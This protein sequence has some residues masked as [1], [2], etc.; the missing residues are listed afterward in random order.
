MK[1]RRITYI[2]LAALSL[3]AASC[4]YPFTPDPEDGSG[5][6]VMEG[7]IF[8]GEY[9]SVKISR[10]M[11]VDNPRGKQDPVSGRVWV[12]DDAGKVYEGQPDPENPGEFSVDT[13]DAGPDRLYSLHFLD[14]DSGSEYASEPERVCSPPVIDSLS[15][16]LDYGRSRLFVALSMHSLGES[17]FKWDY[18]EDWEF[19]AVYN[20]SLKYIPPVISPYGRPSNDIGRVEPMIWPENTYYCYKHAVSSQIMTFSTERQTDDRFVDLEFLPIARDDTRLAYLYRIVVNLEPLTKDAYLYWENVKANSDYRGDLFAPNPSELVGNIRC[21][22][23]PEELVMGYVNVAQRASKKL[24]IKREK[25]MFYKDSTPFEQPEL[26]ARADWLDYYNNGWL[27]Y[28]YNMPGDL[29]ET[30]WA[31]AR[32]VDCTKMKGGGSLV[33]PD[34]WPP[35]EED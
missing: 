28:T 9:T 24:I 15:Y 1:R 2:A 4:I 12:E 22:T 17:F 35:A 23:H 8:I 7:D 25:T 30:Y 18:V 16:I 3:M 32:C 21:L 31:R 14:A 26:V 27:P 20:A 33:K 5:A 19:H 6:L 29:S 34:N 10:T 13:R 11:P